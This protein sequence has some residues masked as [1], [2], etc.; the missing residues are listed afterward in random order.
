[1]QDDDRVR[2][3]HM[4][5]AAEALAQFTEDGAVTTS[6]EI[7]CFSLPW[8]TRSKSSARRQAAPTAGYGSRR[9]LA[10]TSGP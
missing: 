5:D 7:G 6:I 3:L 1:M 4:I 10:G 9:F 2:I 8:C